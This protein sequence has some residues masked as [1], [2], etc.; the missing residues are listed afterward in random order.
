MDGYIFPGRHSNVQQ[1]HKM[2]LNITNSQGNAD[3][4]CSEISP[5][6]CQNGKYQKQQVS[7][8][9]NVEKMHCWWEYKLV[10]SRWKLVWRFLKKLKQNYHMIQQLHS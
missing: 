7:V 5:H 1:V 4:N 8:G 3:Q 9:E 2:R 10:Q 6:T